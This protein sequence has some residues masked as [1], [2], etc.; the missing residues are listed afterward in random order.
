LL[1]GQPAGFFISGELVMY[2]IALESGKWAV[3]SL[4]DQREVSKG[5]LIE[6]GDQFGQFVIDGG[7]AEAAEKPAA[8]AAKGAD[9]SE[10]DD[11]GEALKASSDESGSPESVGYTR[12]ALRKMTMDQ[13]RSIGD[14]FEVKDNKKSELIDKILEAQDAKA[15]E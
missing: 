7:K 6:V 13:V 3:D 10:G 4:H 15:A 2:V 9:S 1:A 14:V 8:E 5:E 12:A 11:K